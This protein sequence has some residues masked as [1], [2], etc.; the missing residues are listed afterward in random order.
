VHDLHVWSMG[1]SEIALTAHLVMPQGHADD[2]FLRD[3]TRD[4]HDRF[5]IDHVT[6]QIVRVPFTRPC[7]LL[8]PSAGRDP[9]HP[10][11]A[12]GA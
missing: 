6:L 11:R 4:L 5:A 9:D 12:A 10:R 3:A 1:T 8:D 2:A 7:A